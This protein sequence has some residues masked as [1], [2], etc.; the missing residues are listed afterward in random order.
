LDSPETNGNVPATSGNESAAKPPAPQPQQVT[1]FDVDDSKAMAG[2]ANFCRLSA[3][4][5]E[6]IIDFGCHPYPIAEP[7]RPVELTQRIVAGWHTAK[8]LLHALQ[9]SV[10]RHE[11]A[12]GALETD[13]QARAR[14]AQ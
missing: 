9:L 2:Y 4:P 3:T 11:T 13:V 6:L 8:R 10:Q 7:T 12:F 14:H 1:H 5:E